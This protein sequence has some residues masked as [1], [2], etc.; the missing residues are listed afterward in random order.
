MNR[1]AKLL[2]LIIACAAVPAMAQPTAPGPQDCAALRNL[3]LPGVALS[4]ISAEW[5]PAGRLPDSIQLPAHC[6]LQATR[7]RRQ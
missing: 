7:D 2:A 1:T 6:R 4:E 5:I 3:Q